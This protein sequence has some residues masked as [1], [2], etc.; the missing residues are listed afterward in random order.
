MK[1]LTFRLVKRLPITSSP[2]P[3]LYNAHCDGGKFLSTHL[4]FDAASDALKDTLEEYHESIAFE[5]DNHHVAL[6][7]GFYRDA[8]IKEL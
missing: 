3:I 6:D 1:A 8:F 4:T 7:T 2:A 5:S